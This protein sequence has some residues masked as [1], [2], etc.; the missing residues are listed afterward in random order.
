MKTVTN[1]F[2]Y[3]VTAK[4]YKCYNNIN[5]RKLSRKNHTHLSLNLN[6]PKV[7]RKSEQNE[8]KNEKAKNNKYEKRGAIESTKVFKNE[9]TIKTKEKQTN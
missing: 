8:Q 9:K 1:L 2:I 7:I 4:R 6:S 5:P 3:Q